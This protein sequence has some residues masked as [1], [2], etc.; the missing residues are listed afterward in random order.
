[1]RSSRAFE[2]TS[3]V[4]DRTAKAI[5]EFAMTNQLLE[6][7]LDRVE[8]EHGLDLGR[9]PRVDEWEEKYY[10]QFDE[11]VRLESAE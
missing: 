7:D 4:T 9:R 11:A 6:T 1:M 10:P 3:S 2:R 5:K 8:K